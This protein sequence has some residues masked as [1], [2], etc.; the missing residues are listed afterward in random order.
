AALVFLQIRPLELV[1]LL[2]DAL[3][4]GD[5]IGAGR[6]GRER[7][8]DDRP[9]GGEEPRGRSHGTTPFRGRWR[10]RGRLFPGRPPAMRC[11]ATPW[12]AGAVADDAR[13][14][15]L[16]GL[17]A[18]RRLLRAAARAA[19]GV[20]RAGQI[21]IIHTLAGR[22]VAGAG[23]DRAGDELVFAARRARRTARDLALA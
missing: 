9:D 18:Q 12:A 23:R 22:R 15:A 17:G 1:E 7:E 10:C 11:S 20:G 14:G 5:R 6:N 4:A 19:V 8:G 2:D 13:R 3:L 16:L 21:R